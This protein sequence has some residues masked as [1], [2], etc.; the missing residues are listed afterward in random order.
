MESPISC[1]LAGPRRLVAEK[2]TQVA[3]SHGPGIQPWTISLLSLW[4]QIFIFD[5]AYI[6]R[7]FP[8][9]PR[10][11]FP[12]NEGISTPPPCALLI[13]IYIFYENWSTETFRNFQEGLVKQMGCLFHLQRVKT[14]PLKTC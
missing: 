7:K 3:V 14:K 11:S 12:E 2:L 6:S 13:G 5:F 1:G 9:D 4:D 8:S 10:L